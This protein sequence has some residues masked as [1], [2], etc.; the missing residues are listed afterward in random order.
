MTF[1]FVLLGNCEY[2]AEKIRY[3]QEVIHI[4]HCNEDCL[5][6]WL[7]IYETTSNNEV[8][9]VKIFG[10]LKAWSILVNFLN[11]MFFLCIFYNTHYNYIYY[12]L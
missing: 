11:K 7:S 10:Q 3:L 1:Y 5:C 6:D 4:S 9:G 8:C 12:N 2:T